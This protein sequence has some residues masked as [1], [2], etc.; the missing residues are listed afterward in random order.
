M[1]CQACVDEISQALRKL[2]GTPLHRAKPAT[3]AH[4]HEG[5]ETIDADLAAQL[6]A[7]RG[8][9]APSAIVAAVQATGR[10]AVVRGSGAPDSAAVCILEASSPLAGD[11]DLPDDERVRGLARLVEVA[12]GRTL[13]DVSVRGVAAGPWYATVRAAG[14]VSRGAA[15]TGGV[16][17]DASP[18]S[19]AR[20]EPRGAL[21]ALEVDAGG[22]G[23]ALLD[24]PVAVWE[25]VGRGLVLSQHRDAEKAGSDPA[26]LVGVVARSAGVWDN[27][28]TVCSC[29]GKTLWEE[30]REQVDRGML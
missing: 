19:S 20:G 18:S 3:D 4:A 15:S 28:K 5:I 11:S 29:T 25:V 8:T 23:A 12:P 13:W 30:R 7:V 17:D 14:D 9:A 21:G 2:D 6:V 22:V 27:D 16:W 24:R 1:T 26:A 10:A